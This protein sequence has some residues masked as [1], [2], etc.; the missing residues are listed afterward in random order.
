MDFSSPIRVTASFLNNALV[1]LGIMVAFNLNAIL[2]ANSECKQVEDFQMIGR[3][4]LFRYRSSV[5]QM[6][7]HFAKV[8]AH[9]SQAE[10]STSEH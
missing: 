10:A 2:Y 6:G 3:T 1:G 8:R 5:R 9:V 7:L 4:A